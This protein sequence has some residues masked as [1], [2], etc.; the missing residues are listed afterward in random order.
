[1]NI[2][3]SDLF[4]GF[5]GGGFGGFDSSDFGGQH[6]RTRQRQDQDNPIFQMFFGNGAQNNFNFK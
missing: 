3:L 4:G 6:F 1:M 2:N 5:G